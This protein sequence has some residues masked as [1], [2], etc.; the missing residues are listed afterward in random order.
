VPA[1]AFQRRR[2]ER[3]RSPSITSQTKR[4]PRARP[5]MDGWIVVLPFQA[6]TTHERLLDR[7]RTLKSHIIASRNPEGQVSGHTR[8][9]R[10]RP[11]TYT[12]PVIRVACPSTGAATQL[13]VAEKTGQ[14]LVILNCENLLIAMRK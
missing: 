2:L 5:G 1:R 6:D 10:D 7:R 11:P 9:T 3:R 4:S 12:V 14:E 8:G 13:S